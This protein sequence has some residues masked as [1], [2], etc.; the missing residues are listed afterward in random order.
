MPIYARNITTL[1]FFNHAFIVCIII[2]FV[3]KVVSN[4]YKGNLIM[5]YLQI[6]FDELPQFFDDFASLISLNTHTMEV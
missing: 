6:N 3:A 5:L 4:H 1:R 2:F